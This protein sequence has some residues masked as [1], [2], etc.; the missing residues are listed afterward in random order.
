MSSS[1]CRGPDFA[2]SII[3]ARLLFLVTAGVTIAVATACGADTATQGRR[4]DTPAHADARADRPASRS[5]SQNATD[6]AIQRDLKVAIAHDPSLRERDIS[7]VVTN[8]DISVTGVVETEDERTKINDLAMRIA[9]V[10][11][12]ANA[13]RVAE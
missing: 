8:G 7:F 1:A 10:K 12:V 3:M 2:I 9:G 11:S 4:P 5:V 6:V 13:L